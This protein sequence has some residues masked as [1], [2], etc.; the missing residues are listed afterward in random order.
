MCV[1]YICKFKG[2]QR[3]TICDHVPI[4][5]PSSE[6]SPPALPTTDTCMGRDRISNSAKRI[7]RELWRY[8]PWQ[9]GPRATQRAKGQGDQV[10]E[11]QN[12]TGNPSLLAAIKEF[13]SHSP[14]HE[15][16]EC[17]LF[18]TLRQLEHG[19]VVLQSHLQWDNPN[20]QQETNGQWF[21]IV[22]H[23]FTPFVKINSDLDH[24]HR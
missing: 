15:P 24:R 16:M 9:N 2:K 21:Y 22:S 14:E 1:S 3:T 13:L 23:H 5:L 12:E 4:P 11:G 7:A 17:F 19:L 10:L 18:Q 20:V 6:L 8:F